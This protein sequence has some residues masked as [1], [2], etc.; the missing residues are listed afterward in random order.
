M[1]VASTQEDYM[2]AYVIEQLK[3]LGYYDVEGKSLYKLTATLSRLR[4]MN[5]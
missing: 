4:A 2:T 1:K 5:S 3:K